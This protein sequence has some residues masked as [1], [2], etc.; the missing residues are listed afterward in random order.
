M[1][2]SSLQLFIMLPLRMFLMSIP[3]A[4]FAHPS[5]PDSHPHPLGPFGDPS[6]YPDHYL[7]RMNYNSDPE[8]HA[9]D[10]PSVV[11]NKLLVAPS[12]SEDPGLRHNH[13]QSVENHHSEAGPVSELPVVSGV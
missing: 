11:S 3:L 12:G 6:I 7:L 4:A 10:S 9:D 8:D 1:L 2:L 5:D 13:D